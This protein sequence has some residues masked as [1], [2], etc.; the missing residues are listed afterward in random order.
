M[1]P[2]EGEAVED[3]EEEAEAL[4]SPSLFSVAFLPKEESR[5]AGS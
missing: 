2:G 5:P 1:T 4:P 3:E